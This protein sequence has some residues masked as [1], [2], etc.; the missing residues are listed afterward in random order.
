MDA[1]QAAKLQ[2]LQGLAAQDPEIV[3]LQ[4]IM[5]F[6]AQV[7]QHTSRCWEKCNLKVEATNSSLCE[8][9]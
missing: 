6:K 8:F 9:V 7:H 1:S 3:K 5:E 4:Q 2:A